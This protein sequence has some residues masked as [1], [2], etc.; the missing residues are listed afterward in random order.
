MTLDTDVG[1][2]ENIEKALCPVCQNNNNCDVKNNA[3]CWCMTIDV[4]AA[5]IESLKSSDKDK[6]CI[7]Q[8][9]IEK[10]KLGKSV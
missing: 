1:S 2:I 3:G 5:L 6:R 8:A 4:P 7:C 9:C 10:F